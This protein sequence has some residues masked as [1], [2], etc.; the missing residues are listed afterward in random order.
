[1]ALYPLLHK[2]LNFGELAAAGAGQ[3]L[4]CDLDTI[5]FAP[6]W[7]PYSSAM[8]VQT[9]LLVKKCPAVAASTE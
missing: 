3:V 9:L 2:N 4:C 7:T 8:P 6:M 5:Y 1:M